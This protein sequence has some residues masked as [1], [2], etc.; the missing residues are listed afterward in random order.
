MRRAEGKGKKAVELIV[1]IDSCRIPIYAK[2]MKEIVAHVS[3]GDRAT[4]VL[5]ES[6][7][8][9]EIEKPGELRWRDRNR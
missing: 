2:P 9:G 1:Y 4:E 6:P 5:F 8:L 3:R 7:V